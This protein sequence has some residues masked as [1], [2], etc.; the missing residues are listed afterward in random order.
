VLGKACD[1]DRPVSSPKVVE[2]VIEECF[3]EA[4][5]WSF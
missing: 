1:M 4:F 5:E 3:K 2:E